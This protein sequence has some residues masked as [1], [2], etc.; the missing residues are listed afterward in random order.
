M[1]NVC[2]KMYVKFKKIGVFD[3]FR[4]T[5]ALDVF[6]NISFKD[7][8]RL[9]LYLYLKR[10]ITRD[11]VCCSC[12][13]LFCRNFT[14]NLPYVFPTKFQLIWPNDFREDF[15]LIGQSQTRTPYGNHFSCMIG[16]KYGNFT[17]H[18]YKVTKHCAS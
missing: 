10:R 8:Y 6:L 7:I 2:W 13:I 18:S 12:V 11:S 5:E 17:H 16:M 1:L 15:F 4:I 9:I 3:I 14:Q